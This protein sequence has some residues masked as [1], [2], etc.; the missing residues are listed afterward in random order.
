MNRSEFV[1][2]FAENAGLT[3]K[4]AK[5]VSKAMFDTI[6][7]GMKNGED[8]TPVA[9]VKFTLSHRSA[10]TAR[11]PQTGEAVDVAAKDVPKVKFGTVIKGMFE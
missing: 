10:R 2:K 1:K 4:D 6:F 7:D 9:G 11:N 5:E 8:V 3:Q